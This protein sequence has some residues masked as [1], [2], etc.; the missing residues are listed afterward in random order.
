VER[1]V[2]QVFTRVERLLRGAGRI[3]ERQWVDGNADR[4]EAGE[5]TDRRK[6]RGSAAQITGDEPVIRFSAG[7]L[8]LGKGGAREHAAAE[9]GAPRQARRLEVGRLPLVHHPN[10]H[11]LAGSRSVAERYR[12]F[13]KGSV[14]F[15]EE[16]HPRAY[17]RR[18]QGQRGRLPMLPDAVFFV[19][20]RRGE[21]NGRPAGQQG[22]V[23]Q[24]KLRAYRPDE[25]RV[26]VE[27]IDHE[28]EG[29]SVRALNN[30]ETEAIPLQGT[31]CGQ[32][33]FAPF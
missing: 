26:D 4:D 29:E 8:V 5:P 6:V 3:T 14:I 13:R 25:L 22:A 9:T 32:Y 16:V 2:R 23:H 17:L 15:F 11:Q 27:M 10:E 7:Q 19:A 20:A 31:R 18:I 24:V 33:V 28:A 12:T 30:G 1:Y 21:R